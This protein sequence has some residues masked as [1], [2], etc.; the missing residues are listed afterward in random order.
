ME[1]HVC[2]CSPGTPPGRRYLLLGSVTTL[3]NFVDIAVPHRKFLSRPHPS[4]PL[5]HRGRQR[6]GLLRVMGAGGQ[7]Q[8]S[9][10]FQTNGVTNAWGPFLHRVLCGPW[11][12]CSI[13]PFLLVHVLSGILFIHLFTFL[14]P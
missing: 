9:D 11:F 5:S 14:E 6:R 2:S 3:E 10:T 12:S 7:R 4:S 13:L 8:A 1:C